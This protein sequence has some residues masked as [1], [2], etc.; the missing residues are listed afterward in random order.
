MYTPG[1]R[2]SATALTCCAYMQ[3]SNETVQLH[4]VAAMQ[5]LHREGELLPASQKE[6][7]SAMLREHGATALSHASDAAQASQQ[8][9][10]SSSG[11]TG[12]TGHLT[13][14]SQGK[15]GSTGHLT[16]SNQGTPDAPRHAVHLTKR[17]SDLGP[18]ISGTSSSASSF[19]CLL[20]RFCDPAR[21]IQ[22]Q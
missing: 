18:S 15:I 20:V 12:S 5:S 1:V 13:A 11:R 7:L 22:K 3:V 14:S 6:V 2:Q 8:R 9:R 10:I 4:L 17:T 19:T 21:C 16:T